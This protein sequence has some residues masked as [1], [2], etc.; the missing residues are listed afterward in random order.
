MIARSA[1]LIDV[2]DPLRQQPLGGRE[3][4]AAMDLRGIHARIGAFRDVDVRLAVG[5]VGGEHGDR[6]AL[7]REVGLAVAEIARHGRR[8]DLERRG[9]AG[10]REEVE[11]RGL[12]EPEARVVVEG[13]PELPLLLRSALGRAVLAVDVA[14]VGRRRRARR[15]PGSTGRR[16]YR[17]RRCRDRRC[18]SPG[19]GATRRQPASDRAV[20]SRRRCRRRRI[21]RPRDCERRPGG[22]SPA[23]GTAH[24]WRSRTWRRSR[25]GLRCRR[26]RCHGARTRARNGPRGRPGRAPGIAASGLPTTSAARLQDPLQRDGRRP[27]RA[28]RRRRPTA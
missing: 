18:A 26:P 7:H 12:G 24:P 4:A 2:L 23:R 13:G 19:S 11:E 25:R 5:R 9:V 8:Q 3:H 1:G 27:A 16:R 28:C 10:A 20:P 17:S 22:R 15:R 6:S 21:S 14:V